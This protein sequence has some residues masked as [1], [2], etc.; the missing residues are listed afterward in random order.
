MRKKHF[1]RTA[2]STFD[3]VFEVPYIDGAE[4]KLHTVAGAGDPD[5]FDIF[6]SQLFGRLLD[7]LPIRVFAAGGF[8]PVGVIKNTLFKTKFR[9]AAIIVFHKLRGISRHTAA[10]VCRMVS[11]AERFIADQHAFFIGEEF[12]KK[13]V[14]PVAADPHPVDQPLIIGM[15]GNKVFARFEVFG[16][17]QFIV[18]IAGGIT[19]GR[20]LSDKFAVDIE[21]VIVI[22]GDVEDIFS[23]SRQLKF[24]PEQDMQIFFILRNM[25]N[26]FIQLTMKNILNLPIFYRRMGDPARGIFIHCYSP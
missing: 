17:I 24:F 20:S 26:F 10:T 23:G 11:V 15:D 7:Q 12:H 19:G 4:V 21:F 6:K 25:E 13:P 18:K 3:A 16:Y 8:K 14:A 22:G 5:W 2:G 1:Y 9:S